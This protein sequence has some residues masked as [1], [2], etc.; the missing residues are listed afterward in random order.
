M[1]YSRFQWCVEKC[2]IFNHGLLTA[3]YLPHALHG[4]AT[5][6]H[7]AV[8]TPLPSYPPSLTH[9]LTDCPYKMPL[10]FNWCCCIRIA[11]A[12]FTTTAACIESLVSS[13]I[14]NPPRPSSLSPPPPPTWC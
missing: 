9:C 3:L 6:A 13:F 4:S 14:N 7:L 12:K 1:P 10:Q 2:T 11:A 8:S 5:P